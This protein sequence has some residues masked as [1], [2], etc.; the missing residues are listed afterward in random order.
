MLEVNENRTLVNQANNAGDDFKR[1]KVL[2]LFNI[3][4]RSTPDA[5]S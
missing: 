2:L 1:V 3:N 4:A 5:G